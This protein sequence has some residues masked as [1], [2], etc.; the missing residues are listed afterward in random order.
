MKADEVE[1]D[2]TKD[3]MKPKKVEGA[4]WIVEIRGYTDHHGGVQFL[5]NSLM[6]NLQNIDR[7][8]KDDKKIGKYIVGV[9][10]PVK[11]KVSHAF[12]F[13]AWMEKA[14]PNSFVWINDSVLD[15]IVQPSANANGPG[16]PQPGGTSGTSGG[17]GPMGPPMG[18]STSGGSPAAAI[19]PAWTPLGG[20]TTSGG[21]G[22]MGSSGKV[23]GSASAGG[24]SGPSRTP[25]PGSSPMGPYPGSGSM[26][27]EP[28]GA[29][30]HRRFEFVVMLV[31]RE[32]VPKIEPNPDAAVADT[33]SGSGSGPGSP[34][35]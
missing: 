30:D 10:D 33:G 26:T 1:K 24:S 12:L 25:G 16:G 8:A 28:L 7:F 2:E 5:K 3:R 19:G 4:G 6:K 32:P 22:S 27:K 17:I 29:G 20:G 9:A 21:P 18:S 11:G 23:M 31:W 35:K 14:Q 15:R 34:P 13:K